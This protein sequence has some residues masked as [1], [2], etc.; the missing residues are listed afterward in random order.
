MTCIED[1]TADK[2]IEYCKDIVEVNP[3]LYLQ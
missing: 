3:D 1:S 2:L